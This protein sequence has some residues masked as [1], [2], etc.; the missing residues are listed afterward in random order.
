MREHIEERLVAAM[1]HTS[2]AMSHAS[3]GAMSHASRAM[4][5]RPWFFLLASWIV[6][7]TY[8]HVFE[9]KSRR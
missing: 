3:R 6:G 8:E 5:R 4:A 7:K 1:S 2:R 9:K